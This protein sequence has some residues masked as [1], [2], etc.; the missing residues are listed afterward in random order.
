MLINVYPLARE[1]VERGGEIKIIRPKGWKF[2]PGTRQHINEDDMRAILRAISI[3]QLQQRGYDRIPI[4]LCM[5]EKEVS[6]LAFPDNNGR[7]NY[8]T[9]K[10]NDKTSNNCAIMSSNIF[11]RNQTLPQ[12][13]VHNNAREIYSEKGNKV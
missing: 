6:A 4:S 11:G 13:F 10:S 3:R 9:F 2:P 8:L 7:L 1:A 5:F 12:S